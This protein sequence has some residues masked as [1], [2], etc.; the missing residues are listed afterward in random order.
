MD[1]AAP[2]S[3]LGRG[4]LGSDGRDDRSGVDDWAKLGLNGGGMTDGT[5]GPDGH[6]P[7]DVQEEPTFDNPSKAEKNELYTE[8][9]VYIWFQIVKC[10]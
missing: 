10:L 8:D 4:G 3:D 9:Q 5:E 7:A 2:D 6:S 1:A